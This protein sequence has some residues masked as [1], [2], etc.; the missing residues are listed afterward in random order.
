MLMFPTT[1]EKTLLNIEV[2]PWD[3]ILETLCEWRE[4]NSKHQFIT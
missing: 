1:N 4:V 2:A 3:L